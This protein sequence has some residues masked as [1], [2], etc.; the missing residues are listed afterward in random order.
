MAALKEGVV[1]QA[2]TFFPIEGRSHTLTLDKI[3]VDDNLDPEDF[4]SQRKAKMA[5]SSW[6][7]PVNGTFRLKDKQTGK[8]VDSKT[9]RILNLPKITQR[10]S[11]IVE[12]NERSVDN[13]WRLKSGIYARIKANGQLES[14]W[15]L[16]RGLGFSI[17][18]DPESR[19]YILKYGTSNVPLKPILSA[20]GVSDSEMKKAW[21]DVIFQANSKVDNNKS[22]QKFY[23]AAMG[24][25]STADVDLGSFVRETF[26]DTQMLP[27][28]N[29]INLGTPFTTVSGPAL[30]SGASKL[31]AIS[32]GQA[33]PDPRDALPFK[34]L[35]G[36]EDYLKERLLNSSR[37]INRQLNNNIDRKTDIRE[38]ITSDIFNKPI[39]SWFS[40]VSLSSMSPQINPM[41]MISGK[42]RTTIL[43]S[44]GGGISSEHA[45]T[46]E[47]KMVDN[48]HLGFLDPLHT[49]E[50][51]KSGVSLHLAL[52]VSKKGTT[53]IIPVINARTGKKEDKS[54]LQLYDAVVAMPDQVEW[55]GKKPVPVADR[56]K[57]SGKAN[58]LQLKPF[59]DVEYILPSAKML[60][61]PTVNLVPFLSSDS[62]NRVEMAARHIEQAISLKHREQP[63]VQTATED[64]R[65]Y[66]DVFGNLT[67]TAAM[68]DGEVYSIGK[69]FIK[70]KGKSGV[71][72][73]Q[74]Y[75][76]FP[77]NDSRTGLW[78]TPLVKVGDKV[79]SGQIIADTNYSREGT[80]S[81]G[82]NIRVAYLPYHGLNFEDGIVIS[83]TAAEELTSQ[84]LYQKGVFVDRNVVTNKKK[85]QSYFPDRITRDQ[86]EKLDDSGIIRVGQTLNT[87]NYISA[88]M[89]K[90]VST[91][92]AVN[93]SRLSKSLVKPYRDMSEKW[94]YPFSGTVVDVHQHGKNISV[95][96]RTEEPIQ[97]GDK[98]SGRHGNKGVVTAIIPDHEMPH[99]KS[100]N[101]VHIL[102]NPTGVA[103]R[104]NPGQ[105]L[106]TA[107]SKVAIKN[108]KPF[109]VSNFASTQ[110]KTVQVKGHYRTV[111]TEEGL[112]EIWVK[113]HERKID[114]TK[115][116]MEELEKAGL[117]DTEELFDPNTG[118]SLGEI[119]TG[120]QYILKLHHQAIKK[121]S[122]RSR[123]SY[124]INMIPKRGG[125]E[126]AQSIGELGLYSLLS[127]GAR[128]NIRD[129]QNYK[130]SKNEDVWAAIQTGEPLPPP[131]T[132]FVYS[133]FVSYLNAMGIDIHRKGNELTLIPL[134]DEEILE[135]SNGEIR[136]PTKILRGKDLKEEAGG[137]FD[138]ITTGGISG[139]FW[140]HISLA[141]PIPNPLFEPAIR[142][143]LGL[144]IAQVTQIAEGEQ[145]V[146]GKTGGI[147]I[148]EM[149]KAIDVKKEL[150]ESEEKIKT[151]RGANLD[152]L[153]KK[154][155]YLRALDKEGISPE[156][157]YILHNLP[158]LP[159]IMRPITPLPDGNLNFDEMNGLYRDFALLNHQLKGFPKGLPDEE[160]GSLRSS[161]YDGIKAIMGLGGKQ[162][163]K[164]ILGILSPTKH[165]FF[166]GKVVKRRQDLTMRSIIVPDPKMEL[167]NI[168]LPRKAA[169]ELFKPFVV[170]ELVR[171]GYTPLEAQEV[172]KEHSPLAEKALEVAVKDRPVLFKRD[173]A[174]HKFA[175]M[176][177][178]PLL[179][180]G[181]AIK[182]H[183][184]VTGAYSAD[185]DGDAMSVY[186]PVSPEAVR[187]AYAMMPTRNLFSPASGDTMYQP[188]LDSLLGL[189]LA[190]KWGEG[191]TKGSYTSYDKVRNDL[192][193]G[194]VDM[195]D[196]ISFNGKRT[197]PGR[198][199]LDEALPAPLRGGGHLTDERLVLNKKATA[200]LFSMVSKKYPKDFGS[201][202]N[203]MQQFGFSSASQGFSFRLRDFAIPKE[204]RDKILREADIKVAAIE[205]GSGTK[206]N[207]D[208][209]IVRVYSEATDQLRK[210]YAPILKA[211][212]N[213]IFD[214]HQ[215]G[216][217]PNASQME[218]L[219]W[220]PMLMADS[221]GRVVPIPIRS[222]YS[223]GIDTTGYWVGAIGARKGI[224]EKV[225][226]VRKPGYLSKQL[227]NSTMNQLITVPD[228]NTTKGI[229]LDS[230]SRN[231]L[232]RYLISPVRIRDKTLPA[233][234][235]ITPEIQGSLLNNKVGKIVVRSPLRCQ[236]RD[237][238]CQ[239]CFG[240]SEDGRPP[241][242][243][244]NVGAIASQSLG[245]RTTQLSMR[246][247]HTGGSAAAGGGV[248]GDFERFV[249]LMKIPEELP[250]AAT[251]AT[252]SGKIEKIES[253]PAGGW[254]VFVGG[255]RHYVPSQLSLKVG[256]GS[257]ISKGDAIS[258][259][260]IHPRE[261]LELTNINRTQNYLTDE[262]D[263]I[264]SGEHIKRR[265]AEVVVRALTNLTKIVNSG[266]N[267]NILP[268]DYAPTNKMDAWNRENPSAKKIVHAPVLRGVDTLA[269]D[270]Q[271]DWLAKMN[272][273][274]LKQTVQ[275]AAMEGSISDLHGSSP[276]PGIAFGKE[277]AKS[278][279]DKPWA[280]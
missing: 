82:K 160:K 228:C 122:V 249:E 208:A 77:L 3:E 64:G 169:M 227:M 250:N 11:F 265:N 50:S 280:Y 220:A 22:L 39:R 8:I 181:T 32:R 202:A 197:T 248:T 222:S 132:S 95:L 199:L 150:A 70:V 100:G 101:P 223:E 198:V 225:Q 135:R 58:E 105:L 256:K 108:G 270:M 210:I 184:L 17:G 138:P 271:E 255:E 161:M 23:K 48:S 209:R 136:N 51:A 18:F 218:Q 226:Q 141:E 104:V 45:I 242:I 231:A 93:L 237:G 38:I 195:T 68:E 262:V 168:G 12:G 170:R 20:M 162:D 66:E 61:S 81:L 175:V 230:S 245:E 123:G 147:V 109:L 253:D 186:V 173:P 275:E 182:I 165:G 143:L 233:G 217:K 157:A 107:L 52:G 236:D 130:T 26:G 166:Q 47:A 119:F 84:H 106:E 36:I 204:P 2:K 224:T 86:A 76:N 180:E 83:E 211:S 13:L 43:S 1:E 201:F 29:K 192:K 90:E 134:T 97:I 154:I 63:H 246:V 31:L 121:L 164:G 16:S 113:P 114:Y 60:F 110:E 49:P 257:S 148:A 74:I 67:S 273:K 30:L 179:V 92:E 124:D 140:S 188:S 71:R 267:N 129:M 153:N 127:M 178:K 215:S 28:V 276:I 133:K 37:A 206:V 174:L 115:K 35:W 79:K 158:V 27:D 176:A 120:S 73:Y 10:Y 78:S 279:T 144:T 277:F 137:L 219:L 200:S 57:V 251:L 15:N 183:P 190:T 254:G 85:F 75:D 126:G 149:L 194:T 89:R 235:L 278:P 5:G 269:L 9:I 112:K 167:D 261:L 98:L 264:F 125:S 177:F 203:K 145:H 33:E 44:E 21:G 42:L 207:K 111:K 229:S 69:D 263:K 62:G 102:L 40:S 240:L 159:P 24:D 241:D 59:S 6:T 55:R 221:S 80:L 238:I 34:E 117:S 128:F 118:R 7:I 116:V 156:E 94:D 258:T 252:T 171:Q 151:A 56:I 99:D 185:F 65:S 4:R 146:N 259:G 266:D 193:T 53:P 103:G 268:G 54:A 163:S 213:H 244:T 274:K 260:P 247:F 214:M 232:D 187:E 142:S 46:S 96:I 239:H 155:R 216:I 189:Y 212:G 87:D 191:K 91:G 41:E 234:T 243:G 72:E 205:A 172:M 14:Q 152:R 88:V 25:R 131:T 272:Y 19:S 139:N 196:F